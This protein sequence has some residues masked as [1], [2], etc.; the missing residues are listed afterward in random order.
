MDWLR[1]LTLSSQPVWARTRSRSQTS[2]SP[3]YCTSTKPVSPR[4]QL[5][6]SFFLRA[7]SHSQ[8][9]DSH[10]APCN[11]QLAGFGLSSAISE[12]LITYSK[13]FLTHSQ[14]PTS[15]S[16][17][18]GPASH[19]QLAAKHLWASYNA[20]PAILVHRM[21]YVSSWQHTTSNSK[22]SKSSIK[23]QYQRRGGATSDK[24]P[25]CRWWY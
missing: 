10:W 20:Q 6:L 11:A 9:V 17:S 14:Q 1:A 21:P 25:L 24:I 22:L 15:L 8:L 5:S 18:P 7:A 13:P 16:Y 23:I 2:P 19:S 4:S 3:Y 12:L